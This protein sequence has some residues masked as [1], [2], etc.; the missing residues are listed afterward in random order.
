MNTHQKIVIQQ[1]VDTLDIPESAYETASA[2]YRHLADWFGR[3]DAK[4]AS[5]SP[6]IFPQGSFRLGTVVRSSEYDLDFTCK[7]REEIKLST[8]SQAELKRLVG[9]D[10]AA[11]REAHG[12]KEELEAK[13][14]CWRLRYADALAFHLDIVPAIPHNEFTRQRLQQSMMNL[15]ALDASVA[16]QAADHACAITDDRRP[17]FRSVSPDWLISNPEGYATWFYSRVNLARVP[18]GRV[19]LGALDVDALPVNRGTLPLQLCIK[20]LKRHRDLMFVENEDSKP[21]SIIITTLAA[22]AYTGEHDVAEAIEKALSSMY[23]LV[24]AENY[25]VY[26]PV[27]PAEDFADKWRDPAY[28]HLRLLEHFQQ[29]VQQAKTDFENLGRHQDPNILAE[30]GTRFGGRLDPQRLRHELGN[31]GTERAPAYS[32][33]NP[34]PPWRSNTR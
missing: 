22:R 30:V 34:S 13:H 8:H 3:P 23:E 21:I 28:S 14:R 6:H 2:R 5:Y 11:Y 16:R 26:N 7:L 17:N 1:V 15:G 12:I 18:A 20:I 33:K 4:C 27:N 32:I 10:L 25:H 24:R 29:W 31:T 9:E 19:V